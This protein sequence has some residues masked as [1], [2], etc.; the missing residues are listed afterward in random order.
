MTLPLHQQAVGGH[1]ASCPA[2]SAVEPP[3]SLCARLWSSPA[4]GG[5]GLVKHM[6]LSRVLAG[7]R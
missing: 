3:G 1:H 2:G 7:R 6:Y 5:D 4:E